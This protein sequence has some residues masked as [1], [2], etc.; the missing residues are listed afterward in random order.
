MTDKTDIRL[1]ILELAR[2]QVSV[3]DTKLWIKAAGELEAYVL[4]AGQAPQKAPAEVKP[5]KASAK[6][7]QPQ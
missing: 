5:L 3:P 4:D 2:P 7:G 1:K 6:S